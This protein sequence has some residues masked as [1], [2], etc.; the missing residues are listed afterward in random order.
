MKEQDIMVGALTRIADMVN[1]PVIDDLYRCSRCGENHKN[2]QLKEFKKPPGKNT[3]WA[4]CPTTG[5]PILV[6]INYENL[7]K[8]SAC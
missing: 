2:V 1:N 3:H 8:S 7:N 4:R 6:V 5:D